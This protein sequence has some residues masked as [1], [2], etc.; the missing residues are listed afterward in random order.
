MPTQTTGRKERVK[1]PMQP[2]TNEEAFERACRVAERI[3]NRLEAEREAR[4][5]AA[6][7]SKSAEE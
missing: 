4:R 7:N 3:A 2:R 1:L 5:V 6:A